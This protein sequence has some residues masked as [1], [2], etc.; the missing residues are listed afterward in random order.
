METN[1]N[2]RG[3]ADQFKITAGVFGGEENEEDAAE[4][5]LKEE[6]VGRMVFPGQLSLL[7]AVGEQVVQFLHNCH[8]ILLTMTHWQ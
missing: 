6:S 2:Y 8:S 7:Q 3:A 4:K 5:K 1:D